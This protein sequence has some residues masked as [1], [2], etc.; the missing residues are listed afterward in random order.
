MPRGLPAPR[1]RQAPQVLLAHQ[2]LRDLAA[3]VGLLVLRGLVAHQEPLGRLVLVVRL[4]R[5]VLR[6]PLVHL[7][8]LVLQALQDPV[9]PRAQAGRLGLLEPRVLRVYLGL[10]APQA[11]LDQRVPLGP[12]ALL[13]RPARQVPRVQVGRQDP[14]GR[15]GLPVPR[16]RMERP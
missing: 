12:P 15:P 5:L 10:P 3:P 9:V 6:V 4:E 8:H 7:V 11:T 1:V 2:V 16:V 14:Q 13:V